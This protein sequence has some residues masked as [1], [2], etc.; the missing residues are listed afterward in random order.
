VLGYDVPK[1][2]FVVSAETSKNHGKA[3]RNRKH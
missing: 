3:K 2:I 1:D